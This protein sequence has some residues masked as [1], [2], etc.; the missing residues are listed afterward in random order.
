MRRNVPL[1]DSEK[2]KEEC[3][4]KTKE[5]ILLLGN[6]YDN[7]FLD[8]E[9]DQL[10]S[11]AMI[12][13]VRETNS[14]N[15]CKRCLLCRNKAALQRS[16][17][18]PKSI[19]K[20][21]ASD[22]VVG[23]D[24]KV[25]MPLLGKR[26]K[27]SAGEATFWM[28][29]SQCEQL[30]CQNG[31][32]QFVELIYKKIHPEQDTVFLSD[33]K[34]PYSEWMYNFCIGL[35]VRALAVSDQYSTFGRDSSI[36]SLFCW[37]RQQL[38]SI[39]M[40]K[41]EHVPNS[42]LVEA[43]HSSDPNLVISVLVNPIIKSSTKFYITKLP[44][45]YLS[46]VALDDGVYSHSRQTSFFLAHFGNLNI[47]IQFMQH[48]LVKAELTSLHSHTIDPSGGVLDIPAESRRWQLI[49]AGIWQMF[50]AF[51]QADNLTQSH[52][53]EY[54]YPMER[55][56]EL[57]H[58]HIMNHLPS[59]YGL[60]SKHDEVSL[61]VPGNRQVLMHTKQSWGKQQ[62]MRYYVIM[63][64]RSNIFLLF[65]LSLPGLLVV[66]GTAIEKY[67]CKVV[68]PYLDHKLEQLH[69]VALRVIQDFVS[70]VKEIA[71]C[72]LTVCKLT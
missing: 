63:D 43:T 19:L 57:K 7:A 21:I 3:Y 29:C 32:N 49:P 71:G 33:L 65:I 17:I 10:L 61:K 8:S 47:V 5:C 23:H 31:E 28:L 46:P 44:A 72:I 34:L 27:K 59:E 1:K 6:A 38:M 26:V 18:F 64:P 9:G 11:L 22:M 68:Y 70:Q 42:G 4:A 62:V 15:Q 55:I 13:L 52:E 66:D 36:S 14:L 67:T 69:P 58:V 30:L 45:M 56:V 24:H 48:S 41:D 12:D 50:S 39:K 54:P 60:T 35:L 53:T 16:H 51:S 20:E 37:C 2:I 25:F 40:S